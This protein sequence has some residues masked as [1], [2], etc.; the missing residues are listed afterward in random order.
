MELT[1]QEL[2]LTIDALRYGL[3]ENSDNASDEEIKEV[4]DL[5]SKLEGEL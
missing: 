2:Q 1:K 5:I 3:D 4:K